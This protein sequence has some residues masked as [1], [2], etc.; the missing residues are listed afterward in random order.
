MVSYTQVCGECTR[1]MEEVKWVDGAISIQNDTVATQKALIE[2]QKK[3]IE[4]LT[5]QVDILRESAEWALA[6]L[7]SANINSAWRKCL[8]TAAMLSQPE[9]EP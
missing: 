2:E 8:D 4:N 6:A 7:N 1:K 5:R 3:L 9:E